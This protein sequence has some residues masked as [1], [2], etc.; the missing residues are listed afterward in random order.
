MREG[1]DHF[2]IALE[3]E[4]GFSA[5]TISA[6]RNDLT[7]FQTFL[8]ARPSAGS[9]AALTEDDLQAYTLFLRE[10]DYATSTIARKTAAIRSYCGYLVEQQVL[11]ADPSQAIASPRVAKSAPKAMTLDEVALLFE[12]PLE[13]QSAEGLRDLAMLRLLYGTG[14]R[15]SE[16]VNLNVDDLCLT[17]RYVRC[18]GKQGRERQAPVDDEVTLILEDYLARAR[19]AIVRVD[20]GGALFLNHRGQRLTR[21][22]FWLILKGYAEAAGIDDIT[23]H[24]L[25]HS[26]ATHQLLEGRDLSH[27]QQVLG[28]VSI[29]TT[30]VYEQLAEQMRTP[31]DGA[32]R[33][34]LAV[35]DAAE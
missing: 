25:R 33:R 29:S 1:I 6:Y 15:V 34:V 4:R 31:A 13:A 18:A 5:N 9:W 27:V 19:P 17:G 3:E 26:F 30:Q 7:Q 11:R 8:A 21:Q 22:G 32:T 20:D 28:H 35:V 2:L 14:M 24:T 12:R 23:P 16:L 10:R